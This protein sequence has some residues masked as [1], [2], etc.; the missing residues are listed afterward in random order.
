MTA[1][2]DARAE[3]IDTVLWL[4]NTSSI[5]LMLNSSLLVA[6]PCAVVILFSSII[7]LIGG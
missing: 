5:R 4:R 6:F 2:Y 1:K 7:K 3:W